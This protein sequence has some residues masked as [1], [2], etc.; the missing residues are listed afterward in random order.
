MRVKLTPGFVIRA[1]AAPGAERTTFWDQ[2]LPGFGLM[3]TANGHKS[4]VVQYRA[5]GASR[6]MTISGMLPLNQARKQ[7]LALLGAVAKG[8]DPLK[9]RRQ[10]AAMASNTLQQIAKTYFGREGKKLRSWERRQADLK[11]LVWPRLG[12]RQIGEIKRSEIARLLDHIEDTAGP[13]QADN[14]LAFLS[15]IFAWHASR[16]DDFRSPIVRGMARTNAKERER[17]RILNDDELREVWRAAES[18]QGPWGLFV[19]FLLVTAVRRTEAA[20]MTWD[21]LSGDDWTIPA[22]RYKTKNDV[23][24]PLSGAAK[25][26]LTALPQIKDCRFLFTT[27]GKNPISGFSQFK[28]RFDQECGVAGW[29]IHDLRRTARS[30]MSRAGVSADIAERCLGHVIPGIRGTY[31]R[32]RYQ[33]EMRRAFEA[34]AAQIERIV[35]PQENVVPL[36]MAR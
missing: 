36:Q 16:D 15:K 31:D 20:D 26:I 12:A 5:N 34:L 1:T 19:K 32:H 30:L 29:R 7:A 6:R 10:K 8:G 17:K 9:E 21:E 14:I 2:T 23:T 18:T 27:D 25:V 11:R 4:Y 13:T 28:V 24:L 35:H 3:V 33:D 22:A